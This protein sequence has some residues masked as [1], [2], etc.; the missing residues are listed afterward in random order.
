MQALKGCADTVVA[1]SID[2][3]YELCCLGM[4]GGRRDISYTVDRHTIKEAELVLC[5]NG[6]AVNFAEDYMRRRDAN[7]MSVADDLPGDKP[8]FS[9]R[10]GYDFEMLRRETLCWLKEQSLI[11][12]PIGAGGSKYGYDALLICPMNAAFFACAL[13][14]M[15]GIKEIGENYAPRGIIYVAPPFRHSHFKG[16]QA[17]VHQRSE[18]CHEVFAYNLYPGPSAKKGVFSMLLDIGES[19]GWIANHASAALLES[20]YENEVVFMHEGASGGGKSEMLEEIHREEVHRCIAEHHAQQEEEHRCRKGHPEGLLLML[21]ERGLDESP[22]LPEHIGAGQHCTGDEGNLQF[23]HQRGGHFGVDDRDAALRNGAGDQ[24]HQRI[25]GNIKHSQEANADGRHAPQQ[26][27]SQRN[28]VFP[29]RLLI[30]F[31]SQGKT[32]FVMHK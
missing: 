5:R 30:L 7:S 17:V 12:M 3:I 28:E 4:D 26:D 1:E 8:R 23:C 21:I 15:Q 20:P 16:K 32:S 24:V 10:Y 27:L 31:L 14:L 13:G 6:L 11:L 18:G 2:E 9:E 22:D 29:Q 25:N 19:E